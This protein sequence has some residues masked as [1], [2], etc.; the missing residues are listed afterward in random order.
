MTRVP[1]G[2]TSSPFVLAATIKYHIRKYKE[3]CRETFE[4]LNTSLYVDDL[5]ACSSESVSKAF[6]LSKNA[7][8][9]LKD[10]NMNLRKFK[11]NSQ[12]LRK[13]WNENGI[14]DVGESGERPLKVL[15]I[16]WNLDNDTFKLDVQPL[17]DLIKNLKNSKRCVL[18][19]AAKIFDPIGP[20]VN[21]LPPARLNFDSNLSNR[22]ILIKRFHYRERLLNMFWTKWSKE[23]IFMLKSAHCVKPIGGIKEFKIDDVLINDEKFPRH[24]WKLDEHS[25]LRVGGRLNNADLPF[26]AKH[27]II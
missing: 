14:G 1:F 4:M 3:K 15:E 9:I 19:T 23:Y 26:E 8:E 18:Q 22:K 20:R 16:I 2:V 24:F 21:S 6:D 13:L 17:L 7:I 12:E 27:Q 25:L 11:T 10:V 5:F